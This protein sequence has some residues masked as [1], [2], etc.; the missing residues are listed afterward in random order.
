MTSSQQST[1][2]PNIRHTHMHSSRGCEKK[3]TEKIEERG[4]W[5]TCSDLKLPFSSANTDHTQ[6][7]IKW[8]QEEGGRG[9]VGRKRAPQ[10]VRAKRPETIRSEP[11]TELTSSMQRIGRTVNPNKLGLVYNKMQTKTQKL[12]P[13]DEALIT[14]VFTSWNKDWDWCWCVYFFNQTYHFLITF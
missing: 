5:V 12:S 11:S 7:H 13:E 14:S 3:R 8:K 2:L 1:T 9:R 6:R 10:S 4:N